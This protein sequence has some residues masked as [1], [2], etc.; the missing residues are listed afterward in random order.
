MTYDDLI[1]YAPL[2]LIMRNRD[3][4]AQMPE[5]VRRA[6]GYLVARLDHDLFRTMLPSL[7]IA[8]DGILDT[9]GVTGTILEIRSIS[10]QVSPGSWL[11]LIRR[12][13]EMLIALHSDNPRG[14]PRFYAVTAAGAIQTF[15]ALGVAGKLARVTV[16]V[17][18]PVLAPAVQ[19]NII[20]EQFPELFEF[21][22]A[23]E[24]AV[25]N[26]DGATTQLYQGRVAE[27]LQVANA[28]ISRRTRDESAQRAVE[29]R[30]I[31]GA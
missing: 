28:Q 16:N 25:F 27:T 26:V 3:T 19:T 11:P 13:E 6:Q 29:T 22:T 15:P 8:D 31:Q 10:V 14:Q 30:N 17:A 18:P 2:A 23:M 9:S 21:A 5:I 7:P 20:S 24:A 4:V 12:S 1:A